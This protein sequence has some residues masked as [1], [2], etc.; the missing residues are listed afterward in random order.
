MKPLGFCRPAPTVQLRRT[1]WQSSTSSSRTSRRKDGCFTPRMTAE[2]TSQWNSLAG[3]LQGQLSLPGILVWTTGGS[4]R[5]SLGTCRVS[6]FTLGCQ[7]CRHAWAVAFLP[8]AFAISPKP[9]RAPATSAEAQIIAP[10]PQSRGASAEPTS[11]QCMAETAATTV[12]SRKTFGDAIAAANGTAVGHASAAAQQPIQQR[13]TWTVL[14]KLR[15]HLRDQGYWFVQVDV[16][17]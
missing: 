12:G 4:A 2:E 11:Q 10:S 3:R 16:L 7:S 5:L 17:D 14:Q 8:L 1:I 6:S 13:R 9:K 15:A